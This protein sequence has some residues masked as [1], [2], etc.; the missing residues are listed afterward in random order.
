MDCGDAPHF[1]ATV[2]TS[3]AVLKLITGRNSFCPVSPS[4]YSV[5]ISSFA[6]QTIMTEQQRYSGRISYSSVDLSVRLT[7]I[8]PNNIC[9]A[10]HTRTYKI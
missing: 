8:K 7:C 5:V 4:E 1:S 3:T 6:V 2:A 9:R 10:Q